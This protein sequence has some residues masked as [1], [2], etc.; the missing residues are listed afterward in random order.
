MRLS[1]IS[2]VLLSACS[3]SPAVSDVMFEAV[4]KRASEVEDHREFQEPFFK[5]WAESTDPRFRARAALALGRLMNP[6]GIPYLDALAADD[7]PVVRRSALFAAGQMGL[8]AEPLAPANLERLIKTAQA[9]LKHE[10]ETVR[11]AAIE[12]LG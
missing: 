1:I 10:D 8:A 3:S 5:A 6:K 7:D 11:A 9:S 4:A 12:A 2:L